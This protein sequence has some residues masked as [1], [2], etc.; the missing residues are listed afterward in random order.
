MNRTITGLALAAVAV[1]GLTACSA[2]ASDD[3]GNTDS[4]TASQAPATQT[5]GEACADLVGPLGEMGDAMTGVDTTAVMDDP[6]TAVDAFTDGAEALAAAAGSIGNEEVRAAVDLAHDDLITMR[7]AMSKV[8]LDG[9][10]SGANDMAT[11]AGEM[12]NSMLALA[13][14]CQN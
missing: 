5:L 2:G 10:L 13:E 8:L 3:S 1:L 11:A 4:G 6:Q 14:L 7:D 9:D 12:Q